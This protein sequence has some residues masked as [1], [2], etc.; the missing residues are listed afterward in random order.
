M[1]A[2]LEFD[3]DP[4]ETAEKLDHFSEI[5]PEKME[6]AADEASLRLVADAQ[7]NAPVDTGRL[8]A[9]IDR[10]LERIGEHAIRV[11]VGSNVEYAPY[12]EIDQRYLRDAFEANA[13][14]IERLFTEAII[15]AAEEAGLR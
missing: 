4:D 10:E 9:S 14:L 12:Q 6:D 13:D 1:D 3:V 2:T 7:R 8:R 5:L 15:E 11:A